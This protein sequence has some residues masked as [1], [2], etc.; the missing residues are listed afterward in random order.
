MVEDWK[1]KSN[2]DLIIDCW[3]IKITDD[4]DTSKLL[5]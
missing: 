1:A 2:F 5:I 4:N 3:Y